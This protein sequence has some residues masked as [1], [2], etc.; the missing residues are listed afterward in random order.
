MNTT[1]AKPQVDSAPAEGKSRLSNP[2][3]FLVT[4]S[5]ALLLLWMI[6]PWA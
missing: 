3:W 4:P 6:V 1:I 2:G 5:V